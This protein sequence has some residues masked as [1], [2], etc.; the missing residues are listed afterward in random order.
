MPFNQRPAS[1]TKPGGRI[2]D[3]KN[4]FFCVNNIPSADY[5]DAAL[6]RRFMSSHAKIAPR[7]RSGVCAWHQRKLAEAIKRARIMALLPFVIN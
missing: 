3:A 1:S 2:R 4:C 6:L 5:K 7:R